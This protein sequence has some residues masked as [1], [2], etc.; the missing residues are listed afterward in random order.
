M[1]GSSNDVE[2]D[3]RSV[4]KVEIVENGAALAGSVYKPLKDKLK[5]VHSMSSLELGVS[6]RELVEIF[7][8]FLPNSVF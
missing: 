2:I 4:R 8:N 3:V 5:D 6:K 1:R 7:S